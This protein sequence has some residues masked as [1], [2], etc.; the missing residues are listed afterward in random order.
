MCESTEEAS[1]AE[2]EIVPA[3]EIASDP[4]DAPADIVAQVGEV[5]QVREIYEFEAEVEE[6]SKTES[7]TVP[8]EEIAPDPPEARPDEVCEIV[9]MRQ[10]QKKH[11]QQNHRLFQQKRLLEIFGMLAQRKFVK[12]RKKQ[13]NH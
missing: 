13:K 11:Q 10:K 1:T 7:E 8:T 5:A 4:R 9:K 3:K 2:Q 6:I 12:L